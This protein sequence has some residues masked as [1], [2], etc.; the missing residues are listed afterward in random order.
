LVPQIKTNDFPELDFPA[1]G[2]RL[3]N[4]FALL[5]KRK[6]AIS[7]K[8]FAKSRHCIQSFPFHCHSI[9]ILNAV[10]VRFARVT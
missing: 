4:A 8:S 9:K 10:S 7:T 5:A 2:L 6:I 1:T 3:V